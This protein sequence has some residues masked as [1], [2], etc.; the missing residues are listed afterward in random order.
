MGT[1]T[2]FKGGQSGNPL[3]PSWLNGTGN[4]NEEILSSEIGAEKSNSNISNDPQNG[5]NGNPDLSGQMLN[6]R[7]AVARAEMTKYIKTGNK[8]KLKSSISSYV[9]RTLGGSKSGVKR[10]STEKAAATKL[11]SMLSSAQRI[12][13]R[14]YVKNINLA[15]LANKPITD[16]YI[17]L[18]DEIC[19]PGNTIDDS[20]TRR[21][22]LEAWE[23][24]I[25]SL[26][27]EELEYPAPEVINILIKEYIS[28]TIKNRIIDTIANKTI[29][30]SEDI[31]TVNETFTQIM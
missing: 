31:S 14:E 1:S 9:R 2:S 29:S 13:I 28:N 27:P 8:D 12:G 21:S 19:P 24:I 3:I 15:T 20:L 22:Y 10:M 23:Y 4:T 30:I 7:F 16:I 17:F 18:V 6:Q 5:E 26:N 25:H 11:A